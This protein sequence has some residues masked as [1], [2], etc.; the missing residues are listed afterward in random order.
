MLLLLIKDLLTFSF[1]KAKCGMRK[2]FLFSSKFLRIP[3]MLVSV[4]S[5]VRQT[6]VFLANR[7][8]QDFRIEPF[9]KTTYQLIKRKLTRKFL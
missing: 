4:L 5:F 1:I 3:S 8:F 6:L 9:A 2:F 7:Q